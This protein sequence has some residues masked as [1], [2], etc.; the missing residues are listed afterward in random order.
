MTGSVGV[1]AAEDMTLSGSTSDAT[2]SEGS[3]SVETV[4]QKES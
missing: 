4:K 2:S 1:R 3:R